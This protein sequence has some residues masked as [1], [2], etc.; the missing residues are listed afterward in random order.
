LRAYISQYVEKGTTFDG[1]DGIKKF[2]K[3]KDTLRMFTEMK[4]DLPYIMA[5]N[6]LDNE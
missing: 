6:D 2:Y 4:H 1:K 3:D 5:E